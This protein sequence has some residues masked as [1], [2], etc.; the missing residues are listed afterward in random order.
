VNSI[1]LKLEELEQ[2]GVEREFA[3]AGEPVA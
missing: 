3:A 1:T 2:R